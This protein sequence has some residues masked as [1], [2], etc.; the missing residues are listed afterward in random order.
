MTILREVIAELFGM[1]VGDARL[2]AAILVVVGVAASMIGLAHL[3]PLLGGAVL[4]VGCLG[5]L[6]GAVRR[7]ARRHAAAAGADRSGG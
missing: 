2:A 5:V 4:L 3:D 7:A 6:L 1:F